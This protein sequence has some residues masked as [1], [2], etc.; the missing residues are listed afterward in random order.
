MNPQIS[1]VSIWLS[2]CIFSCSAAVV[3]S[4]VPSAS[5][6]SV[7]GNVTV[8]VNVSAVTNLY[9]FQFDVA[10]E[11]SKI[12]AIKV[13]EGTFLGSSGDTSTVVGVIG[14]A[15]VVTATAGT[16]IGMTDGAVGGGTLAT[17]QFAGKSVGVSAITIANI[18]LLDSNLNPIAFTTSGSTITVGMQQTC[19]FSLN[20]MAASSPAI[21][22]IVGV[23]VMASDST[24]TWTA[25]SS[26]PWV[27]LMG[28]TSR[29]G[30]GRV[31]F[32]VEASAAAGIRNGNVTVAGQEVSVFQMGANC[33]VTP[34]LPADAVGSVSSTAMLT[35]TTTPGCA[36]KAVAAPAW[37]SFAGASEGTGTGTVQVNFAANASALPRTGLI[38]VGGQ[39]INLIQQRSNNPAPTA[40]FTDVPL[41]HAFA[42]YITLMKHYGITSGCT[43]T[44]YCPD[45]PVTRG[46]MAVFV[47][48][49][50]MGG[51]NFTFSSSPYF[52]DVPTT[53][54]F[55]KWIQKMKE[56]GITSGCTATTYCPNDPV[57][58]GQ[59]AVFVTR[60]RL[61]LAASQTF[62]FRTTSL[63][64]DV[65][66]THAFFPFI[67]DMRESAITSGCTATT[68][69]PDAPT[70]R[71]QMA[72][73][74][75]RGFFTP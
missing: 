34:T 61:G 45:D 71:G 25:Q 75:I 12:T 20:R 43:A 65:P 66:A 36:W 53:H 22:D 56:L 51:D 68:Y 46:Q 5:A 41:S 21:G 17:I 74:I 24:C 2:L 30:S 6:V 58:R 8:A 15:G 31:F 4:G 72:V 32:N 18:Q 28:S 67:Q 11:P 42:D 49:A 29:Q 26:A 9:A 52:T 59:M 69:C 13:T 64:T 39:A 54:Q 27:T 23:K 47:V 70:T 62:P 35:G 33:S 10:F 14:T 63:F 60:G 57:T 3:V 48:R 38:E 37:V 1:V 55:F 40:P 19:S 16:L 7:G 50:V 44:T 73:F